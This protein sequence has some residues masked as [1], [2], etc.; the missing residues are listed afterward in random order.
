[1][2]SLHEQLEASRA[3][4]LI[5]YYLFDQFGETAAIEESA[6]S[7]RLDFLRKVLAVIHFR[8]ATAGLQRVFLHS[9][10]PLFLI[11]NSFPG[12]LDSRF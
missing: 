12:F 6:K 2:A 3:N 4:P 10:F 9:A 1:M 5:S 7:P 8:P 11:R